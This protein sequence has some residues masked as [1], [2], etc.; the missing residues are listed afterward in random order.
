M[1][2][3]I[4]V[5]YDDSEAAKRA[6]ERAIGEAKRTGGRL[7]VVSVVE[8]PV[9]PEGPRY[10]PLPADRPT[11]TPSFVEPPAELEQVFGHARERVGA[12]GVDADFVWDAPDVAQTILDVARDRQAEA[13]VLG[14]HHH[15]LLGRLL[16]T[17]VAAEVEREA[18]CRVIVA[19]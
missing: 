19:G 15:S 1:S 17:D 13:I 4:V 18:G 14:S 6:L 5:G 9:D 12:E 10:Y 8:M 11:E 7:T 2:G 3:A 16:G